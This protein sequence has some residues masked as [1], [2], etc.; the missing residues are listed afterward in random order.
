MKIKKFV[1][2][3][4][5]VT[6]AAA[7]FSSAALADDAVMSGWAKDNI[8]KAKDYR[9]TVVKDTITDYTQN[10][11]RGMFCGFV[12]NTL[13]ENGMTLTAWEYPFTDIGEDVYSIS[14]LYCMGIVNGKTSETFAPDDLITRQEAAAILYRM[15]RYTGLNDVLEDYRLSSYIYYDNESIADWAKASVYNMKLLKIMDGVGNDMFNPDGMF[16]IEQSAS[17]L[18]RM[19][20]IFRGNKATLSESN[21][22]RRMTRVLFSLFN[23]SKF[24]EMKEYCTSSCVSSFF[25]NGYVFGMTKAGLESMEISQKGEDTFTVLADVNM[26]PHENSV[27]EKGQKTTSFY[28]IWQKQEDGK[29]LISEFATGV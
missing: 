19:Y 28:L 18:V 10:I 11:T 26:K 25:G 4:L 9:I 7:A 22:V 24:E 16:T 17:A 2:G 12:S 14:S 27:F 15:Y 21:E 8:N 23:K 6:F 20:D 3:I 13:G 29:Y 1:S 5:A